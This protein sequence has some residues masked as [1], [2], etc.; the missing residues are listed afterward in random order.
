MGAASSRVLDTAYSAM[1][2]SRI[3]CRDLTSPFLVLPMNF[4]EHQV[5]HVTKPGQVEQA[6]SCMLETPTPWMDALDA[7]R[8]WIAQNLGTAFDGFHL[9][10]NEGM[11]IGHLYF[12]LSEQALVPYR[13]EDRVAVLYCEWIHRRHQGKGYAQ[14]LFDSLL[15]SLDSMK[16]KG[17]LVAATEDEQF[18]HYAHYQQRGFLLLLRAGETRL[19]YYPLRQERIDVQPIPIRIAPKRRHPVEVL[20]FTG[21]FCPYEVSAGLLAL[22]VAREFGNRV[23]LKD[24]AATVENLRAYGAAGGIWINGRQIAGAAPEDAIRRAIIDALEGG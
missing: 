20:V 4:D 9:L 19:M 3:T 18:M 7:S 1:L 16:I 12:A 23:L 21:G 15:N 8:A 2:Q 11:P 24:V 22:Q 6:F 13:I 10:D 5:V 17:V 14:R